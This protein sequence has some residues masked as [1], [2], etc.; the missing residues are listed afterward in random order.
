MFAAISHSGAKHVLAVATLL[1]LVAPAHCY[2]MVFE[3][4][5]IEAGAIG[6]REIGDIDADGFSDI[7][8]VNT[9]RAEH[10]ILWYGYPDWRKHTIAD[11]NKFGDYTAYRSCDMELADIDGDGDLDVVGRL[12][13]PKDDKRG[14]NCWF[15]NPGP[16]KGSWM[17]QGKS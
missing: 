14:I 10:T 16:A 9:G 17:R 1:W 15:E 11:L 13:R 2:Q 5:V 8:V 6:H 4:S 12:G 7:A 3:H